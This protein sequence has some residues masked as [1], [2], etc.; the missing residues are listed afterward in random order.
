MLHV[1]FVVI[2]NKSTLLCGTL[3]NK[4]MWSVI[5][6][7]IHLNRCIILEVV[8]DMIGFNHHSWFHVVYIFVSFHVKKDR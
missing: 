8:N 2:K 7:L 4:S 6:C 1:L 3:E 5:N